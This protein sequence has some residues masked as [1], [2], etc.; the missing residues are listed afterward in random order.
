MGDAWDGRPER[1]DVDGWHWLRTPDDQEAPYE[2]RAAGECERGRWGAY[3]VQQGE[4]DWQAKDCA[5]LGPCLTPA[6]VAAEIAQA[7]AA[8]VQAERTAQAE[9]LIVSEEA[10]TEADAATH[11][12]LVAQAVA[13]EREACTARLMAMGPNDCACPAR[14]AN[15]LRCLVLVEAA[16]TIRARGG[17]D[18]LAEVRQKARREGIEKGMRD[19]ATIAYRIGKPVGASDGTGTMAIG[20]SINAARAI[21]AAIRALIEEPSND[22]E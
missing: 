4:N 18:A 9:A 14:E 21:D 5:Y 1:P 13:A 15:C 12:T 10:R 8:A 19:A 11:A 6:A 3:W 22:A 2:W 7:V 16:A 17:T 20:T